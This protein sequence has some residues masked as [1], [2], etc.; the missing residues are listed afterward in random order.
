MEQGH[1]G[2]RDQEGKA[3]LWIPLALGSDDHGASEALRRADETPDASFFTK[4]LNVEHKDYITSTENT[5]PSAP[6]CYENILIPIFRVAKTRPG[7]PLPG[8]ECAQR[9]LRLLCPGAAPHLLAQASRLAVGVT[10][11]CLIPEF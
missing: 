11:L 4:L 8:P 9:A 10:C 6:T 2:A 5:T 1:G 7:R 3:G